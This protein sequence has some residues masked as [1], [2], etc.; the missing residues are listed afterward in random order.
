MNITGRPIYQKPAKAK[1]APAY[2]DAVRQLPCVC[3]GV[4]PVEAHHCRDKPM[5]GERGLY[6]RIPGAAMKSS[7][8]DTIPLCPFHHRMFHLNRGEFHAEYGK[9]YG[10]IALTR[11]TVSSMEMDF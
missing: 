4:R 2:L 1:P 3:C 10:F 6:E 5:H 8:R 11:A 7:D 9:D